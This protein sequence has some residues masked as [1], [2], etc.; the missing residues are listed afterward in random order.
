MA[1]KKKTEKATSQETKETEQ[2]AA[3][4]ADQ[5]ISQAAI[6]AAA[7]VVAQAAVLRGTVKGG[8]LNV[9]RCPK[10]TAPVERVLK[11]GED[12][13]ILETIEGWYRIDGG[14]IK[15][16]YVEAK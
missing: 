6:Q 1:T 14:Y 3:Q 8:L 9:R 12:V 16:E 7:Q 13:E 4:A 2:A 11:N 5:D 15:A 10:L